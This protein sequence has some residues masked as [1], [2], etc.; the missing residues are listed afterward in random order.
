MVVG[1]PYPDITDP[2][3]QEKMASMDHVESTTTRS[4]AGISGKSYYHNL[5]MRAVNQSIGRAI[6]HQSDYATILLL[7]ERYETDARVW[8][9]L[10]KWLTT[11]QRKQKDK[12]QE[13]HGP[14]SSS[15]SSFAS[16]MEYR[17]SLPK[18][19]AL[20][21]RERLERIQSFFSHN[22]RPQTS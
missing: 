11:T 13:R 15:S 7:D 12:Q 3:L 6:R 14:L 4:I 9:G 20:P 1:L 10:P 22:K 17:S 19:T 18:T 8:N 2:V 21:F 5:C 16:C